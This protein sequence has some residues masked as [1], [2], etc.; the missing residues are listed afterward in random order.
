MDK[1]SPTFCAAK[2]YNATIWLDK[3]KTSS[4]H[5]PAFHQISTKAIKTNPSA[6]H[7]T[8]FKKRR[9]KEMLEG[10]RPHECD[11][12]WKVED[13]GEHVVSDRVFK[14]II[15]DDLS[16]NA[17]PSK[18]NWEQ[19]VHLKTLEIAFDRACN[20][21]CSYCNA[22]FS[23]TWGKDIKQNGTYKNL[24]TPDSSVYK[25]DGTQGYYPPDNGNPFIE[26]F[27][28]WW[29]EIKNTL[30]EIRVT[31]GEPLIHPDFWKLLEFIKQ[32]NKDIRVAV[33]SNLCVKPSQIQK[34]V[35]YSKHVELHVYTSNESIGEQAEYIRDGLDW[36]QWKKNY[37]ILSN[38]VKELH[39]MMTINSLC[40]PHLTALGDF[41]LESRVSNNDK[42]GYMSLN[43]LRNPEFMSP[44]FAP[45]PLKKD[46][47]E[48][49]KDWVEKNKSRMQ[50]MEI[51][52]WLRLSKYLNNV[53]FR[54][55]GFLKDLHKDFKTFYNEYDKRRGKNFDKC[56]PEFIEWKNINV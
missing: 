44:L 38:H 7:N 8:E 26:G 35:E 54:P 46:T 25:M 55:H 28:N 48:K 17:I 1:I 12:C 24:I 45:N 33:N 4:C 14:T 6:L 30:Q 39:V 37:N 16:N 56:F 36:V 15:Y 32:E 3:G 43:I 5:H 29:P 9:R 51:E 34:L 50:D 31:G 47:S 2:W 52:S 21:A 53:D 18:Y 49:I 42:T 20:L 41:I 40:L 11:Y 13:I 22:D 23:T 19:D 27:W 10:K